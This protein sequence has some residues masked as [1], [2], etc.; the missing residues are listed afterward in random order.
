MEYP[1]ST[2]TKMWRKLFLG[3]FLCAF[4]IISPLIIAY[5][6]GYRYDWQKGLIKE[7]GAI[8]IDILPKKA[9]ISINN[10][11]IR[12]KMPVR[13]NT[14]TPNFYTVHISAE[15]YYEWQK[16]IEVK[17][18]QTV[19]IKEIELIKKNKPENLSLGIYKNLSLSPNKDF[20]V[21][22][23]IS[24]KAREIILRNNQTGEEKPLP[25]PPVSSSSDST[26]TWSPHN[27]YFSITNNET[28]YDSVYIYSTA[29]P[30]EPFDLTGTQT[31]KIEHLEWSED[32]DSKLYFSTSKEIISFNAK[33]HAEDSL[34]KNN[35]VDWYVYRKELWTLEA[36][37]STNQL[38]VIK[39]TLNSPTIF[40]KLTEDIHLTSPLS[41]EKWNIL[42]ID[43][44]SLMIKNKN[45]S[46]VTILTPT[47]KFR[48]PTTHFLISNYNDWWLLWNQW[49]LLGYSN[50]QSPTLL[51]RSGEQLQQAIPLDKYNT[52]LLVWNKK[53]SI[54][55]PYYLVNHDFINTS[56]VSTQVDDTKKI[57]YFS[58]TID[59]KQGLWKLAY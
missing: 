34:A 29:T 1:G 9:T 53:T 40:Q 27:T 22:E 44:E 47:A 4:F 43:H 23:K 33:N 14:V 13:L 55:Y 2:F 30:Q 59:G 48:L 17:N 21:Y 36:N 46:E 12:G 16:E 51:N 54:F 20:L 19:Y 6:I 28:P 5:T 3:L 57:I 31:E 11:K 26:I 52:L 32:E 8:S 35:F 7:T 38:D 45:Q 49:E 37:T 10:Q 24:P 18:K 50:T 39:N 41:L 42:S 25:A 58:G 56:F 15:N